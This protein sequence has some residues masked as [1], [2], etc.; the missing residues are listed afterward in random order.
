MLPR[1]GGGPPYEAPLAGVKA[2]FRDLAFTFFRVCGGFVSQFR[3][4]VCGGFVYF[5][6]RL[7]LV[8]AVSRLRWFRVS[9]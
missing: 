5:F 7:V 6:A 4:Y 3:F 9:V 1:C 2:M 8:S